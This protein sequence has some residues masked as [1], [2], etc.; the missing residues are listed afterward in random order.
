MDLKALKEKIYLQ[1]QTL[2]DELVQIRRHLH[3]NPEIGYQEFQTTAYLIQKCQ[4][5]NFT[6]ISHPD[7][8]GFW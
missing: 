4:S 6:I 8:T 5:L 7:K 3:Q 2:F 1:I